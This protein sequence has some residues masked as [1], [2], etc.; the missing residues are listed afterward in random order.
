MHDCPHN[1]SEH[2][3]KVDSSSATE[4]VASSHNNELTQNEARRPSVVSTEPEARGLGLTRSLF[5][6]KQTSE[7]HRDLATL[8]E[9]ERRHALRHCVRRQRSNRY[10]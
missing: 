3:P 5:M 9:L 1:S 8:R 10:S 6:P 2:R 4:R 7:L